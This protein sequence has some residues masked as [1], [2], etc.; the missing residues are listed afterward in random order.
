LFMQQHLLSP[1][2]SR[3]FVHL[4]LKKSSSRS[5]SPI[6]KI[7][8]KRRE[9]EK[10]T[11]QGRAAV[12]QQHR[13]LCP[14]SQRAYRWASEPEEAGP[15][16]VSLVASR[17]RKLAG[18]HAVCTA[19]TAAGTV[20]KMKPGGNEKKDLINIYITMMPLCDLSHTMFLYYLYYKW[21]VFSSIQLI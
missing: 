4:Q 18:V 10:V 14:S 1:W 15:G 5:Y 7:D 21:S 3:C 11:R 9:K 6:P 16:N 20:R 17:A 13:P 2:N 19:I 12:I 8:K